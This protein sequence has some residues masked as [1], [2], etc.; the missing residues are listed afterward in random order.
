MKPIS[1]TWHT[2]LMIICVLL[3]YLR[4]YNRIMIFHRS[5]WRLQMEAFSALLAICP[6]NSA[7][8]LMRSSHSESHMLHATLVPLY[9][10]KWWEFNKPILSQWKQYSNLSPPLLFFASGPLSL[11]ACVTLCLPTMYI[12]ISTLQY[13]SLNIMLQYL[14]GRKD[15]FIKFQAVGIPRR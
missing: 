13:V 14:T 15:I 7:V 10:P 8:T 5:W 12:C 2:N 1:N 11:F 9:R 4:T 3:G 6:R